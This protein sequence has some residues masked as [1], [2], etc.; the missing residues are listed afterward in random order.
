ML[1]GSLIRI[2]Q[3][4]GYGLEVALLVA[5]LR[6]GYARTMAPLVVFV[7]AMFSIDAVLRPW[8]LLRY[9]AESKTYFYTYWCTEVLLLIAAFLLICAFFRR[10]FRDR[11]YEVWAFVRP[12]LAMILLL[13]L[14]VTGADILHHY[15]ELFTSNYIWEF[16]QNL[17]FTCLVINTVLFLMMQR[18]KNSEVQ[19]QLLVC[20]LGIQFAGPT[21]NSALVHLTSSSHASVIFFTYFSPCCALAMLGVWLY[22]VLHKDVRDS[23]GG[24]IAGAAA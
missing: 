15:R 11:D 14:A 10:A 23:G 9:G 12:I 8:T 5:L 19:L 6:R 24:L 13:I 7:G 18:L 21:A 1:H 22:A 17:C 16:N 4:G 20:G 3:Y 2:F